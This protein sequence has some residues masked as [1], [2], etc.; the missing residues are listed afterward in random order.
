[1]EIEDKLKKTRNSK[2]GDWENVSGVRFRGLV[3]AV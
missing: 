3:F 1:M 2:C